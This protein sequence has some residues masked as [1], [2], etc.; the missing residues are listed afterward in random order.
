MTVLNKNI[1][2]SRTQKIAAQNQ[3]DRC[4]IGYQKANRIGILFSQTD[5]SK[6]EAVRFLDKNL[7][8]DGKKVDVLCFLEKNGENYDFLYNYITSKDVSMWGKMH[9]GAALTF[10]QQPF[11]YLFYLDIKGNIYLQNILAMSKAKCRI[12]FY[13]K[14]NDDLLELMLSI[15]QNNPQ[16]KEGIEQIFFYTKKLGSNGT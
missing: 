8:K 10:A 7:K 4:T 15:Q 13:E 6:F 1:L 11:D 3:S 9:S 14:S 2:I 5:R 12:G 16:I